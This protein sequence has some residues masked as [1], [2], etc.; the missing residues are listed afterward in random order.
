MDKHEDDEADGVDN[1][2]PE[3]D[4]DADGVDVWLV[5]LAE[6][7]ICALE[8]LKEA[9]QGLLDA[10]LQGECQEEDDLLEINSLF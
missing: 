2:Q 6:E 3:R 1:S 8:I 10:L 4:E 7:Q 9:V 5:K